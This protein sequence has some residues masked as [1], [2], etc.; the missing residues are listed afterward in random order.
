MKPTFIQSMHTFQLFVLL[1]IHIR[2]PSFS[3]VARFDSNFWKN[4]EI[5]KLVFFI[6]HIVLALK[7]LGYVSS[8]NVMC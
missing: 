7:K 1:V 5:F 4:Y 2:P 3:L 6:A 8:V